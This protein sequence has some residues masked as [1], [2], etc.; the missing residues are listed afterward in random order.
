MSKLSRNAPCPC[1]SGQKYKKC[2]G[3]PG[4]APTRTLTAPILGIAPRRRGPDPTRL[5]SAQIR[6][7]LTKWG[8]DAAPETLRAQ[9]DEHH[10]A[11]DVG[12]IWLES[13]G[14]AQHTVDPDFVIGAAIELWRRECAD[15]PS[16]EMLSDWIEQGYTLDN[17]RKP[18]QACDVWDRVWSTICE[19]L[20]DD[21]RTTREV[22]RALGW[23][24]FLSNLITDL[25]NAYLNA[26]RNSADYAE[27]GVR[28][29]SQ[30]LQHFGNES[31]GLSFGIR[32]DL[33]VLLARAGRAD[34]AER[35]LEALIAETPTESMGYC[36][37]AELHEKTDPRRALGI[38]E[39]ALAA[40][41]HNGEDY[42]LEHRISALRR[43][44]ANS[45]K[46]A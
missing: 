20:P 15:R 18:D 14:D 36:R 6:Q 5:D 19:R 46:G 43:A 37:L 25:Q 30:V 41:V 27:R 24:H 8:I 45:N 10:A 3:A 2:C 1:G 9:A 4:K 7:Q 12:K 23:D 39:R 29:F 33:G 17:A 32:G 26:A 11:E 34:E 44:L 22:D 21:I 16:T 38:L 31:Q 28:F 40:P 35:E 13:I 42:D